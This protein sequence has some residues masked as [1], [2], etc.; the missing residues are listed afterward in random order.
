[1]GL[2]MGF[3]LLRVVGTV[4]LGLGPRLVGLGS[5]LGLAALLFVVLPMAG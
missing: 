2:G 3:W 4:G 1:L 5:L